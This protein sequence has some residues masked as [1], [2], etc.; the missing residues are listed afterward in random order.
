MNTQALQEIQ[1]VFAQF[2]L[3]P[4]L[5]GVAKMEQMTRAICKKY[6]VNL[7]EAQAM[8]LTGLTFDRADDLVQ[9]LTH[10]AKAIELCGDNDTILKLQCLTLK[11]SVLSDREEYNLA[12]QVFKQVLDNTHRLDDT[13]LSLAYTNISD[14][15]L[16]LEQ[17]EEAYKLASL[18]EAC[19]RS[20]GHKPNQAI[21][22]LNMGYALGHQGKYSQAIAAFE[23]AMELA[24]EANIERTKAISHSYMAQIMSL[25][26]HY[27]PK[28]VL[29]HF[30]QADQLYIRLQDRHNR[31]ENLI[32][33]AQYL[34]RHHF[35]QQADELCRELDQLVD[36]N[37]NYRFYA[38]L[39]Q[40]KIKLAKKFDRIEQL[41][42]LQAR[43]ISV[44]EKTLEATQKREYQTILQ[45]VQTATI[46]QEM[47]LVTKIRQN[48]GI[49]TKIGQSIAT[50]G[51]ISE[52]L[53]SL[54]KQ[55]SDIIPT[56]EFG[57]A[58]YDE[59]S[60]LLDY[61]YFYDVDG[62]VEPIQIDCTHEHSVG[63]YVIQNRTTV[64]LNYIND[65]TLNQFVPKQNREEVDHVLYN[66]EAKPAQSIILTPIILENRVLGLL[67]TQHSST[68][69][70]QQHHCNLFEQLANFIAIALEN[71]EQRHKL[72]R[73]NEKLKYLSQTDP[74]THLSNRYQ[75]D[76]IAPALIS[77]ASTYSQSF[78]TLMI[79]VDYYKGYNDFYG[80]QQGDTA[81]KRIAEQMKNV[82]GDESDYL[83]RYG[84]DEFLVLS[85]GGDYQTMQHKIRQLQHAIAQLALTNPLS[86]CSQ[87]LTLSVG[88]VWCEHVDNKT[89]NFDTIFNLADSELYMVKESGR[90]QAK[91]AR[92]PV[93]QTSALQV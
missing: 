48:I 9:A 87:L 1:A 27:E 32:Y 16:S 38:V 62:V 22:L 63:S 39:C 13:Y 90:N 37:Q 18:G 74:L 93:T 5:E 7:P 2:Q 82:F 81:L 19:G 33:Y 88:G 89:T 69:Q 17:F 80:H 53:P 84:G 35:D 85:Y 36:A 3:Y 12:Y 72:Q 91:L 15:L 60:M 70:Y 50:S 79:D 42:E 29:A 45:H 65:D 54:Y 26:D 83:F 41:I 46:E 75:L 68:D 64:H 55:I 73:V 86:N 40:T 28:S 21:C 34:E 76:N 47:S 77:Q 23:R 43:Y 44:T 31:T 25:A 66:E 14:L 30:D 8:F 49:I 6:H 52:L 4:G 78:T 92:L 51:D 57:I 58:L 71:R 56:E 11:G 20:I 59:Q 61:R 24:I 67:S 10:Y